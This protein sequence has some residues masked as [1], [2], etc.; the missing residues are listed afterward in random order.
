VRTRKIFIRYFL[1][2]LGSFVLFGLALTLRD[3]M[4]SALHPGLP[5]KLALVSPILP[6]LLVVW[7]VVRH[8][9]SLDEY[10]RLVSL[11]SMA[12]AFGVTM[13]WAFTCGFLEDAGFSHFGL[14]SVWNVG[15][16]T[17]AV[18]AIVRSIANR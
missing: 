2:M 10:G 18:V 15:M 7:V 12:I 3:N 13:T 9:Q 6:F 5:R 8:F 1:E 14:L 16:F 4:E 11:Q 17:W